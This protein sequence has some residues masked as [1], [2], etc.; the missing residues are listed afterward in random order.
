MQVQAHD[1]D[2]ENCAYKKMEQVAL[3][4]KCG[5]M[6]FFQR[7]HGTGTINHNKADAD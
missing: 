7:K 6:I 5:R 2:S 1:Q 3:E 4:K